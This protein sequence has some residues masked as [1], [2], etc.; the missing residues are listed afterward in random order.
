MAKRVKSNPQVVLTCTSLSSHDVLKLT[1]HQKTWL[2]ASDVAIMDK[3]ASFSQ[4]TS[5]QNLYLVKEVEE[6]KQVEFYV[7]PV[8]EDKGHSDEDVEFI[9]FD[10]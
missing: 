9:H 3:D 1:H 4:A 10:I 7:E 6:I 8:V 2:N 5:N